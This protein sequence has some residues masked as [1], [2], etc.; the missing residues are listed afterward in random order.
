MGVMAYPLRYALADLALAL[1]RAAADPAE[2]RNTAAR[3]AADMIGDGAGV[4]LL[5]DDGRYEEISY[6]HLDNERSAPLT[7]DLSRAG[8]APDDEYSTTLAASR[9]PIVLAGES[10]AALAAPELAIT[11]AVLCPGR[12]LLH[13]GGGT[14]PGPRR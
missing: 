6:H 4:Q 7:R 11:A 5:R 13:P 9:R 1:S 3:A 10:A 2:V 14:G 12:L 8:R